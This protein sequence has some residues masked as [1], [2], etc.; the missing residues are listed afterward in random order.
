MNNRVRV[1]CKPGSEGAG[2][3]TTLVYPAHAPDP[4]TSKSAVN[5]KPR[6]S[7][8]TEDASAA[9]RALRMRPRHRPIQFDQDLRRG[10]LPN[11]VRLSHQD[12]PRSSVRIRGVIRWMVSRIRIST[13]GL[14]AAA[15]RI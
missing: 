2:V 12:V 11:R 1:M 4:T 8:V 7:C 9:G 15:W 6:R 5:E 3:A 14:S 13:A 10:R